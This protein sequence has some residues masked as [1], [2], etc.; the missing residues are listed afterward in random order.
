MTKGP[1]THEQIWGV[2]DDELPSV[3]EKDY[4]EIAQQAYDGNGEHKDGKSEN[5]RD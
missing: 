5:I 1:L 2:P 3:Q 4:F